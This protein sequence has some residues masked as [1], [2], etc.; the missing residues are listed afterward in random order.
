[1]A[2]DTRGRAVQAY[3]DLSGNSGVTAYELGPDYIDIEF[4]GG[5][6]YRYDQM[7]PGKRK[8]ESMKVLA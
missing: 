5:S 2:F 1:M 4:K 3:K 6:V 8:L 7:I